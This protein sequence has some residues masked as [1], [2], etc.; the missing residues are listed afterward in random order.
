M[1]ECTFQ[2]KVNP[3][4]HTLA[5][6][7]SAVTAASTVDDDADSESAAGAEESELSHPMDRI[8]WPSPPSRTARLVPAALFLIAWHAGEHPS[9]PVWPEG[10]DQVGQASRAVAADCGGDAGLHLCAPY[11]VLFQSQE[12]REGPCHAPAHGA[13]HQ[14]AEKSGT[15]PFLASSRLRVLRAQ[16]TMTDRVEPKPTEASAQRK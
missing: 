10:Q 12:R 9:P 1:Q 6:R 5:S 8:A 16:F 11:G 15:T 3:T 13:R 7:S 14:D 4:M 2:P